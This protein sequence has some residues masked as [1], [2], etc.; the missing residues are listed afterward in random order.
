MHFLHLNIFIGSYPP[1]NCLLSFT[2]YLPRDICFPAPPGLRQMLQDGPGFVLLDSLRHHIQD[3]MHYL[4]L[5]L[6][7]RNKSC[8]RSSIVK[9]PSIVVIQWRRGNYLKNVHTLYCLSNDR[10][11]NEN[12][13]CS[14][15]RDLCLFGEMGIHVKITALNTKKT[16]CKP[17]LQIK[18]TVLSIPLLCQ[19]LSFAKLGKYCH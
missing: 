15:D 1:D 5:T 4:K 9:S 12:L 2:G 19:V 18:V 8:Q 10:S 11:I 7:E 16:H 3:V 17:E 13:T 14:L 6:K